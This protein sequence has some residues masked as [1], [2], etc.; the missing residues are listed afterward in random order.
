MQSKESLR[1]G[2]NSVNFEPPDTIYVVASGD[3]DGD[4]AGQIVEKIIELSSGEPYVLVIMNVTDVSALSRE[5]RVVLTSNGH[6]LPPRV[7]ALFGGSFTTRVVLDLMDR[8]SWLLGSRNRL[9]KHWPDEK[10]ARAWV[11]EMRSV[12]TTKIAEHAK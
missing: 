4:I 8:A 2:P 3:M 9:T 1:I 11:S 10:S 6:R 5:A 12:L 7:L